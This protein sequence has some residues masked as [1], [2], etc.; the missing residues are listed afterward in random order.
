MALIEVFPVSWLYYH[1]FLRKPVVWA[2]LIGT[3]LWG[4][5]QPAFPWALIGPLVLMALAVILTY[6]MHQ[7]VA[8]P[9]ID[10]PPEAEAAT[11]PLTDG[12]DIAVIDHN[13]VTRAYALDHL[14]H[15][16]IINDRFEDR[17]VAV[18]YCAMCRSI[19][20]F[21]V[22]D[23]GPLFVGS[24]KNANMIVA[25]RRTKTF[26]QQASF[27]S[28]IGRLHPLELTMI[29]YQLFTW[30]ELRESGPVPPFACFTEKD[31]RAFELPIPGVW[32]KIMASEV[33]PGF[34]TRKHDKRLPA[35]THVIGVMER[36]LAPVA[37]ERDDV[38]RAGVVTLGGLG[39]V[40]VSGGGGVTGFQA[41]GRAF[42]L[43]G[44][45]IVEPATGA[46]WSLRG[47]AVGE[48]ADLAPVA[49]SDEYWFTWTLFHPSAELRAV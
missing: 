28:I 6:R 25:D 32:R 42:V 7:A 36:G 30:K 11:L 9:A 8:F 46:R 10:F 5:L 35:R 39:I 27:Q 18:T 3:L 2:I 47:K 34:A 40:L 44:T 1:Y 13:R 49:L 41:E 14:I 4:L 48:A 24:F 20:P 17:I 21:D 33:T 15:H 16:H 31:L 37:L 22:T 29:P 43:D 12:M 19:I 26:F 23:I 38:R 45:E